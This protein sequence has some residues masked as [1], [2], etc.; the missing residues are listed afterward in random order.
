MA[1]KSTDVTLIAQIRTQ[2]IGMSSKE[3]KQRNHFFR[4]PDLNKQIVR[5]GK[6]SWRDNWAL[7]VARPF[8]S[9]ACNPHC[10]VSV[11]ATTNNRKRG[12]ELNEKEWKEREKLEV[13]AD[14]QKLRGKALV[15]EAEMT[16]IWSRRDSERWPTET[17]QI[18][19]DGWSDLWP[20]RELNQYPI[21]FY[22]NSKSP[23]FRNYLEK[24]KK[25]LIALYISAD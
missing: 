8:W 7:C 11:A 16:T 13:H 22:L 10:V 9:L 12:Y 3:A 1:A 6:G 17:G 25:Q 24:I 18:K 23:E 19:S 14:S 20:G 2:H 5:S 4:K 15:K 21:C